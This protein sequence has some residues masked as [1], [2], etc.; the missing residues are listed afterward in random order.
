M[1]R[2]LGSAIWQ[3]G[4]P[5]LPQHLKWLAL[6][7]YFIEVTWPSDWV[8]QFASFTWCSLGQSQPQE[9]IYYTVRVE[10]SVM[11]KRKVFQRLLFIIR[12]LPEV[13]PRKLHWKFCGKQNLVQSD[14][15]HHLDWMRFPNGSTLQGCGSRTSERL[16]WIKMRNESA[17]ES[18]L[19][20]R[21]L[22]RD[23]I[24]EPEQWQ[25]P[26]IVDSYHPPCWC[27][28]VTACIMPP[29]WSFT[30]LHLALDI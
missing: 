29:I 11:R 16:W 7:W 21:A 30:W 15:A 10:G 12:T 3:L 20:F 27:D 4:S 28:P 6:F 18:R 17:V 24:F 14:G 2:C 13:A 26:K 5:D 25:Q 23:W 22:L 9:L 8:R 1:V 19:P